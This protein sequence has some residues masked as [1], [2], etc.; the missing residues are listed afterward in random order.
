MMR[1]CIYQ[2][3]VQKDIC[4][5]KQGSVVHILFK[6]KFKKEEEE[7]ALPVTDYVCVVKLSSSQNPLF[8]KGLFC[9][10]HC[11][12]LLNFH[13]LNVSFGFLL[14]ELLYLITPCHERRLDGDCEWSRPKCNCNVSCRK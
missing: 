3:N 9:F 4:F 6:I 5:A 2:Q 10:P 1:I 11:F 13:F 14:F 12:H 7:E 8:L